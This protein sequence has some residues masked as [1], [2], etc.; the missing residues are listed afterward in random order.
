MVYG[1]VKL[2]CLDELSIGRSVKSDR[3]RRGACSAVCH[4]IP[5]GDT[6][7]PPNEHVYGYWLG[8]YKER[9]RSTRFGL[10]SSQEALGTLLPPPRVI[11]SLLSSS[12]AS[13]GM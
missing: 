9:D 4:F 12:A 3:Q 5:D 10:L 1:H 6:D 13:R 8:N 2:S 11:N 7:P